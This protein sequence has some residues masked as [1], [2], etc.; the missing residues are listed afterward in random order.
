MAKIVVAFYGSSN[1]DKFDKLDVN[2]FLAYHKIDPSSIKKFIVGTMPGVE[3]AVR[4][5][6]VEFGIDVEV[7]DNSD[8]KKIVADSDVICVISNHEGEFF[9]NLVNAAKA[10]HKNVHE[11]IL[12]AFQFS[13]EPNTFRKY[14]IYKP[15]KETANESA[16]VKQA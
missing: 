9:K 14:T 6:A 2:G 13:L 5:F 16:K 3:S 4:D 8:A 11:A 15:A 7:R 12:S 10:A 1:L